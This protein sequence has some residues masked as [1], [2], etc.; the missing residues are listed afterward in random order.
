MLITY[1]GA[2]NYKGN[3]IFTAEGQGD[4]KPSALYLMNPVE[5]YN[6]TGKFTLRAYQQATVSNGI[7]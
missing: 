4:D 6:T 2:T 1:T 7:L 3:I 5:P